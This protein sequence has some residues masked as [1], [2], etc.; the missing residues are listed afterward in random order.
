MPCYGVACAN[1]SGKKGDG[2]GWGGGTAG[3]GEEE[4]GDINRQAGVL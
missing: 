2:R 1:V 3:K 4:A